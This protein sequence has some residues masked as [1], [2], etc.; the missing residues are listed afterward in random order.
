MRAVES[1]SPSVDTLS[2][3][4][5]S[6]HRM[7]NTTGH[8]RPLAPWIVESVSASESCR[9]L[10][11]SSGASSKSESATC[12]TNARSPAIRSHTPSCADALSSRVNTS[13]A[14]V[15]SYPSKRTPTG[16][17]S[18]LKDPANPEATIASSN[19]PAGSIRAECT[20]SSI[21]LRSECSAARPS[22]RTCTATT[23]SIGRRAASSSGSGGSG[24]VA[25][26][27][28]RAH[29]SCDTPRRAASS[30]IAACSWVGNGGWHTRTT[31]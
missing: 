9:F 22:P 21:R 31:A 25:A 5:S 12:S 19:S 10:P 7:T 4:V 2:G 13:T 11:P 16:D 23:S 28:A 18:L 1:S 3:I 26:C 24:P 15:S 27:S 14:A 6:L 8:S 30:A 20:S 29:A 17:T